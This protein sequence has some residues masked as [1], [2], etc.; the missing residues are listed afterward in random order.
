MERCHVAEHV[1]AGGRQDA[2]A[3]HNGVAGVMDRDGV[4]GIEVVELVPFEAAVDVDGPAQPA[5]KD[6]GVTPPQA[7][8]TTALRPLESDN[9]PAAAESGD[10][11]RFLVAKGR[12]TASGDVRWKCCQRQ[13]PAGEECPDSV[14]RM[15]DV[16]KAGPLTARTRLAGG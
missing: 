15:S 13:G 4:D 11:P 12:A 3:A 7:C 5:V 9:V 8:G 1:R 2:Y 14:D 6:Q 10:E 16:R